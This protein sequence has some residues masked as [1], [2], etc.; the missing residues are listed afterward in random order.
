V[1]VGASDLAHAI[2]EHFVGRQRPP[3]GED[4]MKEHPQ[5]FKGELVREILAGRKTQTRRIVTARNSEVGSGDKFAWFDFSRAWVDPGGT[6][7][8]GP[9]PYLKA[10]LVGGPAGDQG[11]VCRVYPRVQVGDVLWVRETTRARPFIEGSTAIC[12]EYVADGAPVL[13][14]LG[15]DVAWWYSKDSCPAIHMPRDVARI[16]LPIIRVRC[17]RAQ[18]ISEA[19]AHAE[20]VEGFDGALDE[21][22]LCRRAKTLGGSPEDARTWFAELWDLINGKNLADSWNGNPW[23]WIYEWAPLGNA[24][25]A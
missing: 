23:V 5:L 10:H 14:K 1:D 21:V 19:D 2:R 4:N 16:T 11:A 6:D 8:F 3:E 7:L 20:G 24:V 15:F 9:G 18:D 17:E 25:A 12:G 22:A 13:E